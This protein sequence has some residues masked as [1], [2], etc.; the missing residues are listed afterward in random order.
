MLKGNFI[1]KHSKCWDISHKTT[2][3]D[4]MV[5]PIGKLGDPQSHY[6]SS[7]EYHECSVLDIKIFHRENSDLLVA[8]AFFKST[9]YLQ[10]KDP[11]FL[12]SGAV[13]ESIELDKIADKEEKSS[14]YTNVSAAL[15]RSVIFII[16]PEIRLLSESTVLTC[17]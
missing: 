7:S 13:M 16:L 14:P 15:M 6:D 9:I 11:V 8:L 17:S 5:A 12:L 1:F 10:F 2:N 3:I 4:Q